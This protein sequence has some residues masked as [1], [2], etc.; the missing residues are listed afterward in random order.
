MTITAQLTLDDGERSISIPLCC[1]AL[2][3]LA[4]A[5]HDQE[6]LA[7]VL[8]FLSRH[9]DYAVREAIARKK[10][11]PAVAIRRL[12]VDPA[13]EVAKELLASDEV[14]K[15]LT[16]DE[17]LALCQRDARMAELVAWNYEDFILDDD[18]VVTVLENHPDASV[19]ATLARNPFVP[20]PVLRRLAQNDMDEGVR[21]NARQ[22]LE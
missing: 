20:K 1:D 10:S 22:I 5:L 4:G 16:N 8:D 18:A 17:V 2:A 3:K 7:D 11:L 13:V 21:H 15:L 14:R 12:A 6:G 9:S 19:R